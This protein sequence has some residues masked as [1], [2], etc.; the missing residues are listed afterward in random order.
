[1]AKKKPIKLKYGKQKEL[2]RLSGAH[3]TTVWRA[4]HWESDTD[5]QE[6]IRRMAKELGFIRTIDEE[7]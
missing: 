4:L 3:K 6:K 1:M 2:I 5:K 7:E